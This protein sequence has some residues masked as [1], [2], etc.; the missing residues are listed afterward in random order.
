MIL[1]NNKNT[2]DILIKNPNIY[3]DFS[4][5]NAGIFL[6]YLAFL[7]N[8][9][10]DIVPIHKINFIKNSKIIKYG[11]SFFVLL[12]TINIYLP[13]ITFYKVILFVFLLWIFF[14]ITLK[15]SIPINSIII[16]LLL[17]SYMFYSFEQNL[18]YDK[19]KSKTEIDNDKK[20]YNKIQ[21]ICFWIILFISLF[22]FIYNLI[23]NYKKGNFIL[24]SINYLF[25][26]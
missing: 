8:F 7:T 26:R 18:D 2:K 24:H 5:I 17:T 19:I 13:H 15:Q 1:T 11:I 9:L 3:Q 10:I 6:F 25:T 12:F 20:L 21:T 14:L 23:K 16:I 22:G 4:L